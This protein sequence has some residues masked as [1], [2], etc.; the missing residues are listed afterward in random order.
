M[1]ILGSPQLLHTVYWIFNNPLQ[2]YYIEKI[3]VYRIHYKSYIAK[4]KL[5]DLSWLYYMQ[6]NGFNIIKIEHINNQKQ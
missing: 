5:F 2:L 4:F 1:L 6:I 3:G